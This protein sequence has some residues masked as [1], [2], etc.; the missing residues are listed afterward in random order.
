MPLTRF[1]GKPRMTVRRI[2]IDV[3]LI[4]I[5]FHAVIASPPYLD[6]ARGH[7]ARCTQQAADDS[8]EALAYRRVADSLGPDGI[9]TLCIVFP[10]ANGGS[11]PYS[12][13]VAAKLADYHEARA[14]TYERA[15]WWSWAG[16]PADAPR[17]SL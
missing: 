16:L 15:R 11:I 14:R 1:L 7:W 9:L 5:G 6:V 17:P 8:R 10:G 4:A 2:M 13:R 12:G 3:A